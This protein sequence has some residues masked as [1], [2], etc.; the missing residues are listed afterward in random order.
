D[1]TGGATLVAIAGVLDRARYA[2]S[3]LGALPDPRG[4]SR[5]DFAGVA[6]G[7]CDRNRRAR[8]DENRAATGAVGVRTE[9]VASADRQS[10]GDQRGIGRGRIRRDFDFA[11]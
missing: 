2:A 3:F 5:H 7:G 6:A 11:F 4:N 8:D 10:E 9:M 1:A